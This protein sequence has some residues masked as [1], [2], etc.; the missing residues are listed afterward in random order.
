[1]HHLVHDGRHSE[2]PTN[3]RDKLDQESPEGFVLPDLHLGHRV[4]LESEIIRGSLEE[5]Q[6]DRGHDQLVDSS[7]VEECLFV[8]S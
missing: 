3:D 5:Y 2:D 4:S 1:M 8:I 6:R 7:S